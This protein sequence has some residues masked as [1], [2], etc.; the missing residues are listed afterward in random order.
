MQFLAVT[1]TFNENT[2][3]GFLAKLK[4]ASPGDQQ[5]EEI[6]LIVNA[7][8]YSGCRDFNYTDQLLEAVKL[9]FESVG[10]LIEKE[11]KDCRTRFD[12]LEKQLMKFRIGR[13]YEDKRNA[14][15]NYLE[16]DKLKN[17]GKNSITTDSRTK[18]SQ[19]SAIDVIDIEE[20]P[21]GAAGQNQGPSTTRPGILQPI[22]RTGSTP[23]I[24]K[25]GQKVTFNLNPQLYPPK[26]S[27]IV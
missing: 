19:V 1:H 21:L 22:I 15:K 14:I 5:Q 8:R 27:L 20:E 18:S 4:S 17:T 16:K 11:Q 2:I 12:G 7:L 23:I 25:L 9:C 13:V 3:E 10:A 26:P 24:P 6:Q